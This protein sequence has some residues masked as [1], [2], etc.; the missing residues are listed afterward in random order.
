MKLTKNMIRDLIKEEIENSLDEADGGQD[1]Q[2]LLQRAFKAI[3]GDSGDEAYI[4]AA[5][6]FIDGKPL[7]IQTNA[8]AA[9]LSIFGLEADA[10]KLRAAIGSGEGKAA[11]A[12]DQG[13]DQGEE[14]SE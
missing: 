12:A 5:A 11:K 10:A 1:L 7:P 9:L 13:V 8:A 3:F 14:S 4:Q 2:A 6:K